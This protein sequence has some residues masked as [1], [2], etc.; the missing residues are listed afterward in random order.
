M[1]TTK[2]ATIRY[3]A[4]DRCF[5]NFGREYKIDDLLE[6][7]NDALQDF[8]PG[9]NGIKRRQLFD[10]IRFMKSEQGYNAPIER[11][12]VEKQPYYR[13]EDKNF[14][15]NNQPLNES[16]S[17]QLKETLMFLH[18]FKGMPQFDWIDDMIVRL[19][20]TLK[21]DNNRKSIIGFEQ[22][23]EFTG[24]K[25]LTELFNAIF[26]KK[27]LKVKYKSFKKPKPEW[28]VI[29]P[30]YLKQ[31]NSRWFLFGL[32]NDLKRISNLALD[33]IIETK[34]AQLKYIENE[35]IDFDEFFYDV[36][37]VSVNEDAQPVKVVLQISNSLWPYI[38]SKPLHGSQS[39]LKKTN[40]YVE[41]KLNVQ[42]NYE[43][44]T[45]L[46]SHGESIKVIEPQVLIDEIK[47]KAER[48]IKR[49]K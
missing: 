26:Y 33:R 12:F 31:Y 43:L 19:E 13:Y 40:D 39:I 35:E 28:L 44:T 36:V 15:I 2:N 1:A 20:N 47:N 3:H 34:G 30:Y 29:H 38:E 42:I 49:Y 9:C 10:D 25:Y 11:Y 4:L 23:Q 21:I 46:F 37:G 8:D 14:S 6:A 16:E 32:N 45:L 24:L 5:S 7:C 18:R 27:P 48:L 41:I 22:N 17:N